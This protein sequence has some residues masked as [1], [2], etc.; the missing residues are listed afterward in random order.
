MVIK[1]TK[2]Y[3]SFVCLKTVFSLTQFIP[4]LLF[5][6]LHFCHVSS[7]PSPQPEHQH[8]RQQ[9]DC[10]WSA[11][12]PACLIYHCVITWQSERHKL[13]PVSSSLHSYRHI[14]IESRFIL[15]GFSL[16]N[17]NHILRLK[18][19]IQTSIKTI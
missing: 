9:C 13:A 8:Y 12:E 19:F 5:T 15:S 7:P 1:R 10:R 17:K 2:I 18:P 3:V 11:D 14:S 16:D 4:P 6:L